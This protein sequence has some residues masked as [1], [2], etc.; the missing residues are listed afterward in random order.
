MDI[1]D[2]LR[3]LRE[4]HG[5]SQREL[6]LRAGLTNGAIS[7]I[8]NNRSSPSVASLKALLD[9][10][11]ISMADFF[12]PLEDDQPSRHFYAAHEFTEIA[13]QDGAPGPHV[14]LRQL[15]RAAEHSLQILQETY[16]PGADTGP[17]FLRHTG[18]EAG[19]VV[20]GEIEVTVDGEARVL[21]A[22]DG[23]LFDSRLPHR[24]RNLS[25]APCE[26]ISACTPPTF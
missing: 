4:R 10:F 24:F 11:P 6:G 18:E 17:E 22:G 15:G 26:V 25:D 19:I 14:S 16:P 13:P 9:A 20:R 8:E 12:Q 23:Y 3:Q 21:R 5:L 2:R 1:G 7:L